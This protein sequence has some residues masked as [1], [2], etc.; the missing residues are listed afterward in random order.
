MPWFGSSLEIGMEKVQIG[1]LGLDFHWKLVR[2][3]YKFA[4]KCGSELV[5]FWKILVIDW[6]AL[7]YIHNCQCGHYSN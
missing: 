5:L 3:R 4:F 6:V 1:N 2:K 7:H